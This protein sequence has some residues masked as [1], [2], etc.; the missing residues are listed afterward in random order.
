MSYIVYEPRFTDFQEVIVDLLSI[1]SNV[2]KTLG[3]FGFCCINTTN[4]ILILFLF[5]W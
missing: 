5:N 2:E 4:T 1:I 3:I